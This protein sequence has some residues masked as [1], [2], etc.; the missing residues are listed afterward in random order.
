[1]EA[2]QIASLMSTE[3]SFAAPNDS[4]KSVVTQ[5]A[6]KRHSCMLIAEDGEPA[7]IITERDIVKLL[8]RSTEQSDILQHTAAEWMS[9]PIVTLRHDESLFDALVVARA[10]KLRHLPI[11]DENN[12]LV[13]LVTQSDLAA[14]HFHVVEVQS[15]LLEKAIRERTLDL[16]ETN[17]ELQALSMEDGLLGIGNRRA[18]EV[19]LQ[20]THAAAQRYKHNYSVALLDVDYFKKYNDHYGHAAGDAALKT[21]A[22][23]VAATIR[24]SDRVYRYGGEELLI[25]LPDTEVDGAM[26]FLRRQL[27]ALTDLNV[28]HCESP[29]GILTASAGVACAFS[30]DEFMQSW[31]EVVEQADKGLYRAK[32]KSR[33]TVAIA[34]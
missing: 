27:E 21:V 6:N 3:L 28:P 4:L 24:E 30:G 16:E 23:T 29:Y 31:Q 13:G 7:G 1:M 25:L 17:K 32:H 11:V 20:H 26:T 15:E 5:M 8:L 14:A 12:K 34:A 33:N 22:D 2:I 9:S 18:M 19:D 10:E